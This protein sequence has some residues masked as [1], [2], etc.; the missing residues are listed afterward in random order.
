VAQVIWTESAL[1]DLDE[2]AE[3]IALE[4]P[5]AARRF[6]QKVFST[7]D[8]L[9]Q[10]PESG[11]FPPELD[12]SRYREVIVGPC[13]VFYRSDHDKVYIL[14]SMRG[15]RQLRKYLIDEGNLL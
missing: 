7:V 1:S 5:G 4:D 9:E 12:R 10:Y 2:I 3:Y 15:E 11:R 14:F 8:R 13:R 6:V